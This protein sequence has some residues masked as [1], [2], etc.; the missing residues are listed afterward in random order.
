MA[1]DRAGSDG[2]R[3]EVKDSQCCGA[4]AGRVYVCEGDSSQTF[5]S[6]QS[7]QDGG[8]AVQRRQWRQ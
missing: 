5:A 2:G 3:D 7:L 4:A 8:F 6:V 1:W